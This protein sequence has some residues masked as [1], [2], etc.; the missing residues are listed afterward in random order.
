[1]PPRDETL[2]RVGCALG[3]GYA[4]SGYDEGYGSTCRKGGYA[5]NV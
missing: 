5:S 1:M 2:L 4:R 3:V